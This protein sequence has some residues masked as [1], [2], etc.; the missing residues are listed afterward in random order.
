MSLE[1]EVKRSIG[2]AL[3]EDHVYHDTTTQSCFSPSSN[4]RAQLVLKEEA[5]IAAL[6]F[7]PWIFQALDPLVK[8][9]LH[10]A[11][12]ERCP[13]GKTLA[14]VEGKTWALLAAERTAVNLIQH[15]TGIATAA[16]RYV[17][18]IKGLDCEILDT[19]KTLPG[20]RHLQKYAVR[21]GGGVNHRFHLKERILIKNNHLAL[22]KAENKNPIA[23]AITKARAANPQAKIEIEVEDLTMIDQALTAGA[24]LILLDNMPPSLVKEAVAL[25]QKRVYLE[26]SGG[27][28]L[29]NVRAYAATGVAGVSIG[30]LTHSVKAI[31]M[32]L[33]M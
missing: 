12:G 11:E 7:L 6:R 15:A 29:S 22:L 24:D 13:A 17:E 23:A 3:M 10:A 31:D 5:T 20:L 9:S 19:R 18:E 28:T 21:L 14:T 16:A 30:A 33:R 27:I 8:I 26:A 32:S 1:E 25:V 2:L 4:A